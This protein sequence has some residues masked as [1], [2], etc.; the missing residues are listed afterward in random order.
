MSDTN[1]WW[2]IAALLVLWLGSLVALR[3]LDKKI[4]ATSDRGEVRRL[5]RSQVVALLVGS[6]LVVAA[7]LVDELTDGQRTTRLVVLVQVGILAA[8]WRWSLRDAIRPKLG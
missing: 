7:V 5:F 4:R 1:A 2:L 8:W 6:A 3:R